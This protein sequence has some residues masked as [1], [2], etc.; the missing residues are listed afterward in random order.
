MRSVFSILVG[1]VVVLVL[2][3]LLAG[4][5]IYS[6]YR[7]AI[8]L[9]EQVKSSWAQVENQ[10][11]RRYDLIPNLVETVRGVAGHEDKVFLGIAEARKAYFQA[12]NPADRARAANGVES[13]L[14]RLL[15]LTETYPQL[16]ANEAFMKLQDQVEGTENRL[17]VER[18]RYNDAVRQL[19]TFSRQPTGRVYSSLAGVGPAEY[20]KAGAQAQESP[21][22]RFDASGTRPVK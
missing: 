16:R 14:S 18:M 22:I 15:M 21:E 4:G 1:I 6:G 11:K 12:E 17:A 19:N 2:G 8:N 20:F 7:Q 5:C 10:L 13:A 9:D 3:A